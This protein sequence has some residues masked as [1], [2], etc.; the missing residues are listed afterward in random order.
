MQSP[1]RA[2]VISGWVPGSVWIEAGNRRVAHY[3]NLKPG[4]YS[5]QVIAANADGIWNTTGDTVQI[6]LLPRLHQT[7]WFK[8]LC[9]LVGLVGV[10]GGYEAI[11]SPK[12]KDPDAAPP[13]S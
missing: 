4:H 13:S 8:A 11:S 6:H 10:S 1:K 3:A 5:F 9:G 7:I 12:A 2:T